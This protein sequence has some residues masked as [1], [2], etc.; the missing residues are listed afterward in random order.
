MHDV[1][2]PPHRPAGDAQDQRRPP[3]DLYRP[4]CDGRRDSVGIIHN[5]PGTAVEPET[6]TIALGKH[7]E[8]LL[9][10]QVRGEIGMVRPLDHP[11]R[12]GLV[13]RLTGWPEPPERHGSLL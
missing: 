10:R 11:D 12:Q 13:L 1:W 5:V 2:I 9:D 4:G 6:D 8:G 3:R 7:T